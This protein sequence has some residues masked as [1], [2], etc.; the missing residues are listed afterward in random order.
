MG[1]SGL[2][3]TRACFPCNYL[4]PANYL[5]GVWGPKITH[6]DHLVRKCDL[7]PPPTQEFLKKFVWPAEYDVHASGTENIRKYRKS[8]GTYK[9]I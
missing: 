8:K 7:R 1:L 3:A 4:A 9:E 6:W 2:R 5:G